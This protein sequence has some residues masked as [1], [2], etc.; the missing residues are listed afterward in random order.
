MSV[1]PPAQ[2][3]AEDYLELMSSDKKAERAGIKM[4]DLFC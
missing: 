2:I 3:S 1:I 4:D